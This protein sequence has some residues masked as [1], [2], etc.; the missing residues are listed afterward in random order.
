MTPNGQLQLFSQ[1]LENYI[2]TANAMHFAHVAL[3]SNKQ[4][5]FNFDK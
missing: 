3:R 1:N 4:S 2:E 5:Q